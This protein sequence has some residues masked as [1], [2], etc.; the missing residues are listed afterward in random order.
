MSSNKA[1]LYL[2]YACLFVFILAG[3]NL[4][5]GDLTP[6]ETK[7]GYFSMASVFIV[8]VMMLTMWKKAREDM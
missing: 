8:G 4:Y 3:L 6:R 1:P 5:F 2:A 7:G